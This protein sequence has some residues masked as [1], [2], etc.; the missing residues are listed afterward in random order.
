VYLEL[1]YKTNIQFEIG[2]I[3]YFS[4][5]QTAV[6]YICGVNPKENW[7]KLYVDLRGE[8]FRQNAQ[9]YGIVLR[10]LKRTQEPANIYFDNV[11]LLHY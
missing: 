11:K 4:N 9:Q 3:S 8:I 7:N 1:D 2:V 6:T 10:A 5:G